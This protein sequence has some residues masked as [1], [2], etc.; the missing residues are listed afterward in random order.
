MGGSLVDAYPFFLH[1]KGCHVLTV[2]EFW[3]AVSQRS[4]KRAA[5]GCGV[6]KEHP[7]STW[8]R[9]SSDGF[10]EIGFGG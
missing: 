5:L 10:G 4:E 8:V 1:G 9:F 2:Q 6:P 7:F 3:K